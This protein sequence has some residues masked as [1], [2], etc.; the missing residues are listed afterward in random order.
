LERSFL[1]AGFQISILPRQNLSFRRGYRRDAMNKKL[2][3]IRHDTPYK[4][5]R[6]AGFCFFKESQP[7]E[8]SEEQVSILKD[9]PRI[10]M[11][12]VITTENIHLFC[13]G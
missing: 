3:M 8:L 1:T 12:E 4:T 13:E 11:H 10:V 7:F 9:D 6:R 5:Y 2:M